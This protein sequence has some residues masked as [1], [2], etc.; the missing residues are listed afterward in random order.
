MARK[1]N[2]TWL[3]KLALDALA[4]VLE[5]RDHQSA[6]VAK[7]ERRTRGAHVVHSK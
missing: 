4:D 5:T 7:K 1:W 6:T 2:V 3:A